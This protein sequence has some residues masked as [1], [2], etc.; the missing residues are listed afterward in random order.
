[1]AQ[2]GKFL[3]TNREDVL[4]SRGANPRTGLISPFVSDE[5]GDSSDRTDYVRVRRE[6]KDCEPTPT[7]QAQELNRPASAIK[8][9]KS[10]QGFSSA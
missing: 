2:K 4:I 3:C 6:R 7:A 5:I 1:M 8:E 10:G 9:S